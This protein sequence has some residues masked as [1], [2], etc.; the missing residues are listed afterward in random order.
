MIGPFRDDAVEASAA[1]PRR[2]EN[3][4]LRQPLVK[5]YGRKKRKGADNLPI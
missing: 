3:K 5:V 2:P 1:S 4:G